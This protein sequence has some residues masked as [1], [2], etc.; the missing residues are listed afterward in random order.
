M[1]GAPDIKEAPANVAQATQSITT[2]SYAAPAQIIP[3]EPELPQVFSILNLP[4]SDGAETLL[5]E[6]WLCRGGAA[7]M[8]G[9]SGLGKSSTS[10]QMDLCWACGREAFGIKPARPLR[11]LTIQ[12][13]ND[14]GDMRE[15]RDGVLRGCSFAP[16]EMELIAQNLHL[17]KEQTRTGVDF[18]ENI[19]GPLLDKV[20]PDLLRIDP[21]AA[22]AGADMTQAAEAAKLLRNTL[23]PI[24]T[25]YGCGLIL[26]HH[27]PKTTGRDT[28]KWNASDWSYAGAGSADIVNWARA[29]LIMEA[30]KEIGT[31]CFIAAKRGMRIGWRDAEGKKETKRWFKH[32]PGSI[33]WE[34]TEAPIGGG[35]TAP[36][37]EDLL[38][39][40]PAGGNGIKRDELTGLAAPSHGIGEKKARLLLSKLLEEKS[41]RVEEVKVP[42]TKAKCA[43]YIRRLPHVGGV[44]LAQNSLTFLPRSVA[45]GAK[46]AADAATAQPPGGNI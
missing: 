33:C 4:E 28:S 45:G 17:V 36:S 22:Y 6:R 12:A 8:V 44:L 11:I 43:I 3:P 37:V 31:A 41:P 30:G 42:R 2:D 38:E 29:T 10:M 40:I 32:S 18:V 34:S 24:L 13:E 26:V 25:E 7:L 21:L 27:T 14:M 5:G 15:M 9:A 39:L 16:E 46:V 35:K 20:K 1:N 23:N 19:V